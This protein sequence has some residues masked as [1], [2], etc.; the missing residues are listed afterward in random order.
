MLTKFR[1]SFGRTQTSRI[2]AAES[3]LARAVM[4]RPSAK[5]VEVVPSPS[6]AAGSPEQVFVY[7]SD[8]TTGTLIK[9]VPK[10]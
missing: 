5:P 9:I 7:A 8:S 10:E 3:P 6:V 4:M 1:I 2:D